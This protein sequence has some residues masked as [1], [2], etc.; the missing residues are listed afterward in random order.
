MQSVKAEFGIGIENWKSILKE[1]ELIKLEIVLSVII[2]NT[3]FIMTVFRVKKNADQNVE[4]IM[5]ISEDIKT[6]VLPSSE[7]V[8]SDDTKKSSDGYW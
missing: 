5:K 6:E 3:Y 2:I 1:S 8:Q 4:L 7:L